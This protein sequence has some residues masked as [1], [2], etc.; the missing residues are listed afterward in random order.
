MRPD[1]LT[2]EG[3]RSHRKRTTVDFTSDR[4]LAIVGDTGAGKSSLLSALT[5]ALYANAPDASSKT[6]LINDESSQ[7]MVQLDFTVDGQ[8]WTVRRV[9]RRA[10]GGNVDDLKSLGEANVVVEG[11]KQV[12]EK[13][14][15]LLG[16][17]FE[18]FSRAVVLPQG[19]FDQ[20][21][22]A[23]PSDRASQLRSLLGV[24][25]IE[26]ASLVL[27]DVIIDVVGKLKVSQQERASLTEDPASALSAAQKAD[28]E[29][30]QKLSMLLAVTEA[31][32]DPV[33]KLQ[34]SKSLIDNLNSHSPE[35]A[36]LS[37]LVGKIG[38]LVEPATDLSERSKEA[39]TRQ[40]RASDDASAAK[41]ALEQ[42]L[43]G[44]RSLSELTAAATRL[45]DVI[46]ALPKDLAALDTADEAV[47]ALVEDIDE[48]D[49]DLVKAA[50][51]ANAALE[52]AEGDFDDAEVDLR[53]ATE[54]L[55]DVATARAALVV[56]KS[57]LEEAEASAANAS[58]VEAEAQ[59]KAAREELSDARDEQNAHKL[60]N[61]V[62]IACAKHSPGDECPVCNQTIQSDWSPPPIT[63]FSSSAIEL[64]E[65]KESQAEAELAEANR[66]QAALETKA[67]AA[68]DEVA[69]LIESQNAAE[70]IAEGSLG[71]DLDAVLAS[72]QKNVDSSR[73][74]KESA[75]KAV[76]KANTDLTAAREERSNAVAVLEQ[77]RSRA[78]ADKER[79]EQVLEDH[80]HVAKEA[81]AA[82][83][84]LDPKAVSA[85]TA[86]LRAVILSAEES[87]H[88]VDQAV[89]ELAR[90][91]A[92]LTSLAD[93]RRDILN[94]G[95]QL[96]TDINEVL[97]RVRS[98]HGYLNAEE[99]CDIPP[100]DQLQ[101]LS[102]PSNIDEI[103]LL[104]E[105]AAERL[106]AVEKLDNAREFAATRAQSVAAAADA[107]VSEA[108]LR[109][110]ADSVGVLGE[111]RGSQEQIVQ[112]TQSEHEQAK[113]DLERSFALDDEIELLGPL[114]ATL[115]LVR[116]STTDAKFGRHLVAA[117]QEQLLTEASARLFEI[118]RGRFGFGADFEIVV[119]ET[120]RKRQPV[121]LSGG[122][123]FQASLALALALV[124]IVTRGS[125]RL[126][127]V[128]IDEGFGSLDVESLDD[129]LAS[130]SQVATEGRLVALI[131]HLHRVA[132]Y[133]DSVLH[134]REDD[135]G[136]S[137]V[138]RLRGDE[139][140]RF[141]AD[142]S[143][144]GLSG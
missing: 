32:A 66:V 119:P 67:K 2:L 105:V 125:G 121:D 5:F 79:C 118:S 126:E 49:P 131:S 56:A 77:E 59:L 30:Q 80:R 19:R 47:A 14:E 89:E 43:D 42:A 104:S 24:E 120:G 106:E 31:V 97:G 107:E 36:A 20:I 35:A 83:D 52:S 144:S 8:S 23:K 111:L 3:F 6:S 4:L 133:V 16:L 62:S 45:D 71:D 96:V 60:A 10:S 40:D 129:A 64:A 57:E 53:E 132:D 46:A 87:K 143:R 25:H 75:A 12:N 81:G 95:A 140:E 85:F 116:R 91:S 13:V 78:K 102:P 18:Q 15:Q 93:E 136:G 58:T 73:Q 44:R 74:N 21:L 72:K 70:S 1:C 134:V 127:S 94:P 26:G 55:E 139:L 48:L 112:R 130:L 38:E 110:G 41:S 17:D 124:E 54:L 128:F 33:N 142:D 101:N 69:E 7:L 27:Q 108:L 63:E 114:S 115:D 76:E 100:L 29:A 84:D 98:L 65:N 109:I 92:L 34:E 37:K 39:T 123:R 61:A 90:A 138:S 51:E 28:G 137:T 99:D 22:L 11:A 88:R 135:L 68:A 103:Q 86:E 50:A 9:R 122:E 82:N 117:R 141:L 113:S